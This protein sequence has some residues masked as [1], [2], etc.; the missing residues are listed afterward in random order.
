MWIVS[1]KMV[2]QIG[3][4]QVSRSQLPVA[5]DVDRPAEEGYANLVLFKVPG[6]NFLLHLM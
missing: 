4:L 6:L 3:S 1:G 2:M 5:F